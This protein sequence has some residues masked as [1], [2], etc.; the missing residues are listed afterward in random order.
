MKFVGIAL[1]IVAGNALACPADGNKDAMAAPA[2]SKP[3]VAAKATPAA[4]PATLK[5]AT[6]LSAKPAAEAPKTASL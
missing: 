5:A 1:A 6:R 2:M 3:V 4:T